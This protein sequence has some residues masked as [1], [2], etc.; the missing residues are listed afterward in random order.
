T[1]PGFAHYAH[2]K[3]QLKDF[4]KNYGE[5]FTLLG[6][7]NDY[8][9]CLLTGVNM[10]LFVTK[11][12]ENGVLSREDTGG[13]ELRTGDI[14]SYLALLEKIIHRQDIGALMAEGWHPLCE[15]LGVNPETDP[16]TECAITKG[17]DLIVDARSSPGF[18]GIPSTTGRAGFTPPTG[19]GSIVHPKAKHT[20]HG[21]YFPRYEV[22][23]DYIK[24]D[25]ELMG[26]TKEELNRIF[27]DHSFNTGRLEKYGGESE[28]TYN[29]LGICS[30]A[31]Q[32]L[33]H[34]LRDIPWL[35][36]LYSAA[37]GFEITP[38]ELLRAGERIVNVEKLLNVREGFTREDDMI[39]AVYLQNM[40]IPLQDSEG[41]RY[42]T[43]WFG[44]R[45]T[46]EGIEGMLDSYYE[47]RGWDIQKGVPTKKRL[48]ELGLEEFAGIVNP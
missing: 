13:L 5:T 34:P 9:L 18:F 17:I 32:F 36:E 45:L 11:M 38:R 42:L 12:Y 16:E 35:A 26:V 48:I 41:D 28:Y 27:T 21:S 20:H 40:E 6:R 30:S 2:M 23:F 14:D 1:Y 46:R 3:L 31:S 10:M 7:M 15:R 25:A 43:D 33:H 44:R 29:N 8:G 39:P 47:E 37:T 4:F 24:R 22:S 19:L